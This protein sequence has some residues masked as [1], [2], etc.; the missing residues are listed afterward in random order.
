[1]RTDCSFGDPCASTIDRTHRRRRLPAYDV[2]VIVPQDA[3]PFELSIFCEVFGVDRT[4]DGV[5]PFDF[6]V[7]SEE[8]GP[9]R[10][11][12]GAFGLQTSHGLERL[13]SAD[14]VGV[15]PGA[16]PACTVSPAVSAALWEAVERGARLVSVCSGSF[17]LAAAGVLDGRSAATHWMHEDLLEQ[18]YPA[19]RVVRDVLFV[20]DGPIV[21]SAGTAAGIDA[22]LHLLRDVFGTTVANA[23]ARRMVVSPARS[24]GQAQV[25]ESSV[26]DPDGDD[27]IDQLIDWALENLHDD[28]SVEAMAR[29]SYQ[30]QRSLARRFR[31]ATGTTPHA[32]VLEQ[33]LRRAQQLLEQRPDL[34]A[35]EIATAAGF[36]S[37]STMRQHFSNRFGC[38]PTEYRARFVPH[39]ESLD[40]S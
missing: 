38:S 32:W 5:P 17:T 13:A 29:H 2:A 14:L 10:T 33:R 37:P 18:L 35:R 22:C 8:P 23:V 6:A 1:M 28:L 15:A 20:H 3:R 36:G 39:A 21:T 11:A 12:G 19:V 25:V 9:L 30:S 27:R 4:A 24:G 7:V 16:T 26:P 40:A 34:H 31:A